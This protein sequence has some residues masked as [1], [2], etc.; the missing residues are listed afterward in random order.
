MFNGADC[1]YGK[2]TNSKIH[3]EAM[4]SKRFFFIWDMQE[5]SLAYYEAKD[6]DKEIKDHI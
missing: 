4:V 3:K 2:N 6:Y 1:T 5:H